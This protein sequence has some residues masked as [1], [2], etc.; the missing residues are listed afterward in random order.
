MSVVVGVPSRMLGNE[1]TQ[2]LVQDAACLQSGLARDHAVLENRAETSAKSQTVLTMMPQE[3]IISLTFVAH[4]RFGKRRME[5]I[6]QSDLW[7]LFQG[8]RGL[9]LFAVEV[10]IVLFSIN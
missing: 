6:F 4:P 8:L 3:C 2:K 9:G 1:H 7:S 5:A 10:S